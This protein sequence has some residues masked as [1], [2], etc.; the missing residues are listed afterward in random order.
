[1]RLIDKAALLQLMDGKRVDFYLEDDMFEIEGLAE[2]Q[3]DT[4]VIKV[5]DAVGHILEMC[6][7]DL[8]IEAKNRRLYAKRRDT[9]KI[10]EMEINRIYERLVDPDAEAFLHK[11][12]F[13][14]E[15]F[16][17][18][19]TDTLVWFDE[20]EEKWVIEL[21]KINMYFSGNRTSY[22]SLEQLFAA[23]REHME[24][25]WQAITY[26]SAVE[27]DDTYGKDCC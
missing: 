22:E 15:Q 9:G 16:F 19:K 25:D 26:S 18:K 1:M 11:W 13:G 8:E 5:L 7:D 3:N 14:V 23:N 17:H 27:D 4:V 20:A 10:F 12:N 6:G 21:N 2:C 24:G